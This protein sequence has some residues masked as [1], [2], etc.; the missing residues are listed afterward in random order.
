MRIYV[1]FDDKPWTELLPE[2]MHL[3]EKINMWSEAL[4]HL[5]LRVFVNG[6]PAK[7]PICFNSSYHYLKINSSLVLSMWK[8]QALCDEYIWTKIRLHHPLS[9]LFCL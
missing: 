5:W 2:Y 8:K 3:A 9:F 6:I 1:F 4:A 7:D